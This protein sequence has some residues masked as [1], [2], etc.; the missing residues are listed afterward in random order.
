MISSL[1]THRIDAD[2]KNAIERNKKYFQAYLNLESTD[3]AIF[4]NGLYYDLEVRRALWF[5]PAFS[6]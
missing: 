4:L 3:T 2:L 6:S 1:T 5:K